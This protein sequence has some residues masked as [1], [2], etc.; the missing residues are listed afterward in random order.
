VIGVA[1]AAKLTQTDANAGYLPKEQLVGKLVYNL[2][3]KKLG[4]VVNVLYSKE[5]IAL[6]VDTGADQ[7]TTI[8]S[9]DIVEIGDIVLLKGLGSDVTVAALGECPKCHHK[10]TP[11]ARFCKE[12][13]TPLQ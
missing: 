10:N 7:R 9:T 4:S 1:G 12:C 5:G 8:Q 11:Q 13:G 3:A 2:K 6:I